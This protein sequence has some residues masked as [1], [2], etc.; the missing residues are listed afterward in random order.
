MAIG[1]HALDITVTKKNNNAG[2]GIP[3]MDITVSGI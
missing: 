2:K 3:K 1:N